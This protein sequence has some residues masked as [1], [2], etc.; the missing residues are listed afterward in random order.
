MTRLIS[1]LL[2]IFFSTASLA[3]GSASAQDSKLLI[4]GDSLSAG[5]NMDIKQ[6]WPSLLP[7]ALAKHDKAVTVVNGS[8]SGDTTG[9]GLARLPQLL[10]E[11]APD[12][13][14]IEL[15]ANDGLRGF[16]PK[17]MSSNLDQIIEQIKAA[18]AKPI[19]MQIKIPPNYGKRY[20]QQFEYVF[21]ALADQQNVPLLPFFL[22]HII[23]TEWM[24][25]DGLHPKPEAQPWI[26]EFVAEELYQYL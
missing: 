12:T 24:M 6:S 20:N 1:F 15:G 17:L 11:H 14:L 21:A 4:L 3:Q 18:G 5:Y 26:A 7:D 25:N 9:N 22:E 19:M 10:E 23:L 2:F 13:V 8:I 16:P